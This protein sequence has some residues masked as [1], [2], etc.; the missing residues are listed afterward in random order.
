M[1][2]FFAVMSCQ[3]IEIGIEFTG[4][5]RNMGRKFSLSAPRKGK[6]TKDGTKTGLWVWS[7]GLLP[8]LR[9]TAVL[10]KCSMICIKMTV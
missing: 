8:V 1:S 2:V 10:L 5:L 9:N 4:H 6:Y 3:H 7:A